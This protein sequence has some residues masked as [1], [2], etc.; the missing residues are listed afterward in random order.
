[1][2]SHYLTL[3]MV[4][5]HDYSNTKDFYKNLSWNI[6]SLVK[7]NLIVLLIP[8]SIIIQSTENLI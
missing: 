5:F 4:N 3:E 8:Q 1:M 6:L 7:K 2:Q